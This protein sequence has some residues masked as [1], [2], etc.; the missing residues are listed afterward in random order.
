MLSE[1]TETSIPLDAEPV[2]VD[3]GPTPADYEASVRAAEKRIEDEAKLSGARVEER[4]TP[5]RVT[6]ISKRLHEENKKPTDFS[7]TTGGVAVAGLAVGGVALFGGGLIKKLFQWPDSILAGIERWS[8]AK[9]GKHPIM[10]HVVTLV[11]SPLIAYH[12]L[13]V[14]LAGATGVAGYK[15]TS[16]E[17]APSMAEQ[18]VLD[19]KK[20]SAGGGGGGGG[21]KKRK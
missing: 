13:G 14:L 9:L 7:K 11:I 1:T 19:A 5:D 17:A 21:G 2:D 10:R 6:E 18:E 15:L 8:D 20:S 12:Y 4:L 16:A 3:S